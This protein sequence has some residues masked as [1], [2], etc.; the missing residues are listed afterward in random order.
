MCVCSDH[1]FEVAVEVNFSQ[2]L[3]ESWDHVAQS[4]L[5]SVKA[6]V[7]PQLQLSNGAVDGFVSTLQRLLVSA[8]LT[9]FAFRGKFYFQKTKF[10]HF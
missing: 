9:L 6:L 3:D 1:L 10:V 5:L 4:L 8:D 7:T 2:D